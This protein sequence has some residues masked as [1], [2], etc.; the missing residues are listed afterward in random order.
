MTWSD[1]FA[2]ALK[3]CSTVCEL[4]KKVHLKKKKKRLESNK[5]GESYI[6]QVPQNSTQYSVM[7]YMG[8][9][10]KKD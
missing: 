2:P 7:A 4:R 5:F 10:S 6:K 3:V 8:K 9:E 1:F